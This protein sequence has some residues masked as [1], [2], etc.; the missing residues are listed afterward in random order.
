[1]LAHELAH[2]AQQGF[3]GRTTAQAAKPL[4]DPSDPAEAEADHAAEHTMSCGHVT[5]NQQPNVAL[6]TLSDGEAA[7]IGIGLGAV[8]TGLGIAALAEGL[9]KTEFSNNELKACLKVLEI[10]SIEGK[11]ESDNKARAV[12][13]QWK[14]GKYNCP[15]NTPTKSLLIREMRDGRVTD[16]D[17]ESILTILENTGDQE[18]VVLLNP[19]SVDFARLLKDLNSDAYA[20]RMVSLCMQRNA[21]HKDLVLQ[22]FVSWYAKENFN[23]VQQPIAENILTDLFA[24]AG[25][26]FTDANEFKNEVFK[27]IRVS[28]LLE[29][30]QAGTNGFEYPE[31]IGP[32]SGCAD[33]N[34][35]Q[36]N[37]KI[38]L[39][40]ARV[41]KDAREYWTGVV[42]DPNLIFYFD[43]TP[44]GLENTCDALVKLFTPQESICDKTLFHFDYLINVI[45]FRAYAESLGV[46]KFNSL[47]S[48]GRIIMRL[49][50][51]GIPQM[52]PWEN[53][54]SPKGL[55]S[56]QD[57]RPGAREDLIIGD[58]VTFFNHLAFDGLSVRQQSP[59]R[60]ENA[61]LVDK[62]SNG[63]D[64]FQGHGSDPKSTE[65]KMLTQLISADGGSN[66]L[67]QPAIKL[68][69]DIDAGLHRQADLDREYPN[70]TKQ[71]GKWKVID[72][73]RQEARRGR[74]YDLI[75]AHGKNTEAEPLLPGLKDPWN[76]NELNTVDRP[77]E[78]A[79]GRPPKP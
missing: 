8:G 57:F 42:L 62:D 41:T 49:T 21:L 14:S 71:Q 28:Q 27:R 25:L 32:N 40:N 54:K 64:L 47:V 79:P 51:S 67:A 10:G 44:K 24:V 65:H 52:K 76:T 61:V 5:V 50:W 15:L 13:G 17:C 34:P 60:F 38:N 77:I 56:M 7:E 68:T 6:H 4:S 3:A 19:A 74:V 18:I 46:D 59:W 1:M 31:N 33:Y 78:S 16:D 45:Q 75:L 22:Q 39:A 37:N 73:V 70:V 11:T 35:P 48:S 29:E 9:D 58:H 69:H 36:A 26:D 2:V 30:S 55:G 43:L 23:K 53:Q 12:V 20:G 63:Q 72:P 66:Y